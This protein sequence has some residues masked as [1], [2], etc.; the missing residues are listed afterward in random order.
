MFLAGVVAEFLGFGFCFCF[1]D[2]VSDV[3]KYQHCQETHDIRLA[4][5]FKLCKFF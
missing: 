3:Q 4:L 1:G 2:W 5:K